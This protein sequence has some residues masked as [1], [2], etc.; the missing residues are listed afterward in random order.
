MKFLH[1]TWILFGRNMRHF[2]RSPESL[3]EVLVQPI[4]LMLLFVYVFGG[5]IDVGTDNYVNYL[6]PGI[7]A[8]AMLTGTL[9]TAMRLINDRGK[10]LMARFHSMPVSRPSILWAQVLTSLVSNAISLSII[11]FAA[12][13]I[14]FR[15]TAGILEW[16]VIIAML[17]I[18]TIA[19]SWFAVIPGLITKSAEGGLAFAYPLVMLPF[20]SSAFVP[21]KTMPYVVR[22]FAENQPITPIVNAMR[23]LLSSNPV[24]NDILIAFT[25]CFV[26][27]VVAYFI[28]MRIYKNQTD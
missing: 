12:F 17:G 8:M 14:G 28:S 26:I 25:W 7:L 24:G 21:T 9:Y 11:I 1:D 19:L 3:M 16:V 6:L 2:L 22:I 18:F 27:M 5:A 13:I 10:G 15:S 20:I 23:S 4:M